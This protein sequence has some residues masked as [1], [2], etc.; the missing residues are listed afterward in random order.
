MPK[1]GVSAGLPDTPAGLSDKEYGLVTPLYRAV[2]SL[3]QYTAQLTGAIEYDNSEA[4]SVDQLVKLVD[5]LTRKVIVKAGENINYGELITL[6][7]GG[8]KLVAHRADATNL[9]RPAHAVCDTP[10]GITVN[11][12]GEAVFM[13]GRTDGIAGTSLGTPYYL[14][15]AGTV[16]A[17]P[18]VATGV[19][20]QVVGM[21]LGSAG[22]YL[23]IELAARR[24]VLVYKVNSTTLRVLYADGTSVD[25]PV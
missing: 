8:G 13:Q 10:G 19:I 9:A 14:S 7:V 2:N 20:N 21:G 6:S 16:Q 25:N 5:Q 24:P 22:F 23:N 18:P 12:F 3:A 17:T 15:V 4:G 11:N 1:Y